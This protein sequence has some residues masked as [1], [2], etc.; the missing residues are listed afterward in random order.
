MIRV[1]SWNVYGYRFLLVFFLDSRSWAVGGLAN[2]S[3]TGSLDGCGT[4]VGEFR[5][6]FQFVN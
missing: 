5:N 6:L 4:E 3:L 1:T 2:F